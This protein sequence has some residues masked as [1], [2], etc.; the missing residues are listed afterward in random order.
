MLDL[1]G[2]EIAA[3]ANHEGLVG[4]P[5]HLEPQ[6][7]RTFVIVHIGRIIGRRAQ[8]QAVHA[9]HV[10]HQEFD[11]RAA[12]RQVYGELVPAVASPVGLIGADGEPPGADLHLKRSARVKMLDG[13]RDLAILHAGHALRRDQISHMP[14]PAAG[15][16]D[17]DLRPGLD[18]PRKRL[19]YPVRNGHGRKEVSAAGLG[20]G[21]QEDVGA[22][23]FLGAVDGR[24]R[25]VD[26]LLG[27]D[28][29]EIFQEVGPV[30]SESPDP[31]MPTAAPCATRERLSS[32]TLRRLQRE[33]ADRTRHQPLRFHGSVLRRGLV[34]GCSW[35]QHRVVTPIN[36]TACRAPGVFQESLRAGRLQP[37]GVHDIVDLDPTVAPAL[38]LE[39]GLRL[40]VPVDI[41][42]TTTNLS[43]ERRA[44][45]HVGLQDHALCFLLADR[46]V[47]QDSPLRIGESI[48]RG[49]SQFSFDENGTVHATAQGWRK[50][51]T[52]S[53]AQVGLAAGETLPPRCLSPFS[54]WSGVARRGKGDRH[55][56][57]KPLSWGSRYRG[58]GASPRFRDYQ[59]CAVVLMHS[60]RPG[61][62]T[63]NSR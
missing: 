36:P 11:R 8:H 7:Q 37:A 52:G 58:D 3:A 51:G 47:V 1:I 9:G 22:A 4:A 17:H 42:D 34:R 50:M 61:V 10:G 44:Y 63:I 23:G 60:P 40:P 2:I 56:R 46:L 49:L 21:V 19:E 20:V 16:R 14:I 25:R 43:L 53:V 5:E 29:Q 31:D 30:R 45:K 18:G 12:G 32:Q 24:A 15:H 35:M 59:P 28:H 6:P 33:K 55:R 57:R 54:A 38:P 39:H 48:T 41:G 27:L 13:T 62:V 26:A